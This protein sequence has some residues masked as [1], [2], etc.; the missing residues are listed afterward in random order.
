MSIS[1]FVHLENKNIFDADGNKVRIQSIRLS[2]TLFTNFFLKIHRDVQ[3]S[4][5]LTV[6]ADE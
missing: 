1:S 3:A 4:E 5:I 2:K 6:S